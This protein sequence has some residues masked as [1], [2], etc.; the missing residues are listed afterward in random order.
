[1]DHIL[2]VAKKNGLKLMVEDA[3]KKLKRG[4]IDLK[5]LIKV[6]AIKD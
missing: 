2:S 6:I 5:E 1:M 4:D 3:V